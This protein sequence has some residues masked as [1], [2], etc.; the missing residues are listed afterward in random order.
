MAVDPL[1]ELLAPHLSTNISPSPS[2]RPSSTVPPNAA[3]YLSHLTSLSLSALST[4][5]TQSLAQALNSNLL[6]L[7]ALSS[8]SHRSVITSS[9]ALSTLHEYLPAL[10]SS[11]S[12]LRNGVPN[13]DEKAVAFSQKYSKSNT[14]NAVLDKRKRAML[15]SR[16]VD[17]ISDILELPTLLPQGLIVLM[18]N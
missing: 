11:A 18:R 6:S 3:N 2:V 5:E 17:R 1:Y 15:L 9:N 13:L 12:D 14:E 10:T 4:T 16:N 7:Q 8:K